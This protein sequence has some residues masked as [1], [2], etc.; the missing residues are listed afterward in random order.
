MSARMDFVGEKCQQNLTEGVGHDFHRARNR[1][2]ARD[3]SLF[4]YDYE[5]EHE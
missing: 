5:H 2:H 3:R 4:D 1:D